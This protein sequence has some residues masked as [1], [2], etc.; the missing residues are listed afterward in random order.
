MSGCGTQEMEQRMGFQHKQRVAG[1]S[2]RPGFTL[3]EL[4]VVIAIIAL[5]IG[6]L[7]PAL[8]AARGTARNMVCASTERQTA[9]LQ[10]HY[11]LDNKDF[12]SGPNTSNLDHW[13]IIPGQSEQPL[14]QLYFDSE[15][16]AP[17]T[18]YD[19]LSPIL[20]E[21]VNLSPNRASRTAQLFNDYGCAAA[22]VYNDTVYRIT[23][24]DDEE[25]FREILNEQ[26]FRQVS[27]LAP[28]SFYYLSYDS[29]ISPLQ[30]TQGKLIRRRKETND[31][32]AVAPAS[33]SPRLDRV[34]TNPA[35]KI[36]FSDGTR[37]ASQDDGLD[38]DPNPNPGYFSSFFANNPTI[39]GSSAFGREPFSAGEVAVPDN[40]LLSYRHPNGSMNA[41]YFDGHAASMSQLESYSNPNPW[42]PSGSRWTGNDATPEAT[43][44]MEEQTGGN[45]DRAKIY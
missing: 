14:D 38:F 31:S 23:A 12:Y 30:V 3:I 10:T 27:Y 7:L 19:W 16:D 35:M 1:T 2:T 37:F 42:Y 4:L 24:I 6:I 28:T 22:N 21:A 11:A 40:Q 18:T 45:P 5:L 43:A 8:G 25:Q 39:H 29:P 9:L 17:T 33:F 44:F 32:V 36:M 34:G 13:W 41:A 26:G 15:P 20:G